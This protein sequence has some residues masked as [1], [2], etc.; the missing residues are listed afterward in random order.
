MRVRF[1]FLSAVSLLASLAAAQQFEAFGLQG[2]TVTAMTYYGGSLYAA[3]ENGGVYRRYLG[4]LDSG[5]VHLGIP[6]KNL[7]AI[8][9]FHTL[10]PLKCWKGVLAGADLQL[11]QTNTPLIYFY[12][13]RPDT[14]LQKGIW[15][16]ADSGID[17]TS[18]ARINALGGID[19]CHPIAP[20]Y[21]TAF[22]ATANAIWRSEDRGKNWKR[23]WQA[24][25]AEIFALAARPRSLLTSDDEIWAGGYVRNAGAL[26]SVIL[27]STDSGAHWED[28]SPPASAICSALALHPVDTNIVLATFANTIIKS[29]D[30]GKT[31]AFTNFPELAVIF[32][33]IAI[34]P[35]Q[36]KHILAGGSGGDLTVFTLYESVDAGEHWQRVASPNELNYLTSSIS[37]LVFDQSDSRYAYIATRGAGVYRYKRLEVSVDEAKGKPENFQLVA[38]F[39]NPF[40][41]RENVALAFRLNVPS[42]GE[43]TFRLFNIVGQEIGNWKITVVDGEQNLSLPFDQTQLAGGIYFLQAE[44]RG[45]RLTQK[46]TVIR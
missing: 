23:V 27:R 39:P 21:V 43:V 29:H 15:A 38:N 13:Q 32:R 19:V 5:W 11:T 22:A 35:Q 36:P 41:I 26:T 24:M 33:T 37:S 20:T 14:C 44:W 2:K 31:W 10:C 4:E 42:T 46:L 8:F 17:R 6:A 1:Y 9:A 25:A 18:V 30:A 34:N 3:T 45:H 7:T 12:Q 28:R 40:H 16:A